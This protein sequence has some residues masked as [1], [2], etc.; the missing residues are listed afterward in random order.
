MLSTIF[1]FVINR[2]HEFCTLS[3]LAESLYTILWQ[4]EYQNVKTTLHLDLDLMSQV[5]GKIF[6]HYG[7]GRTV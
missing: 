6:L 3:D 7:E 1:E 4:H 5:A 2:R